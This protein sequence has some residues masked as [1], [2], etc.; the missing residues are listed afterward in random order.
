MVLQAAERMEHNSRDTLYRVPFGAVAAGKTVR[1]AILAELSEPVLEAVLR[2]WYNGRGEELVPLQEGPGHIWRAEL[3]PAEKGLVWYSF[4]F[5]TATR[6]IWYGNRENGRGGF[7]QVYAY[8]PPGY[9]LTVYARGAKSPDWLKNSIMYQIF[10]DRFCRAGNIIPQK[11]GAV[12]HTCWQDT[13]YYYREKETGDILAYDFFGGNLAG[14]RSKLSYLKELG[15]SLIYLNPIFEAESNHRYDTGDYLKIDAFLGRN[16]E[17]ALLVREA[18]EQGIRIILDG[19]FSHTG[20]NSRY[21][22]QKGEYGSI[23]AV[24]SEDSPYRR[25]YRFTDYPEK[26]ECWWRVASLPEVNELE[27]SYLD[28]IIRNEKSVLHTWLKAG[29]SGW[30]LDVIDE[31]PEEFLRLFYAELKRTAPEA[32]VIGEVWEDAS[33]KVSYGGVREYLCGGETDSVMNYPLRRLITGFLCG[34]MDGGAVMEELESLRENYPPEN[35]YAL[36]NMLGTHDVERIMTVLGDGVLPDTVPERKRAEARL[37]PAARKLAERRLRAAVLWQM[38]WPGVPSVYYG[39]EIG[40]EGQRD[41]FNRCPYDWENGSAELREFFRRAIALRRAEPALRTGELIPLFGS[42]DIYAYARIIRNGRDV[43]GKEA[44]N[45]AFVIAVNR[46]A[47]ERTVSLYAGAFAAAGEQLERLFS[48]RRE[49]LT[50]AAGDCFRV[51]LVPCETAV[52]RVLKKAPVYKREAGI[53]LHPTAL[54][55][56][57]GI[58]DIGSGARA[59]VDFL[60]RAGMRVW[61][62][63]PLQPAGKGGSP[64]QSPSA[65]AFNPLLIDLEPLYEQGLLTAGEL[66]AAALPDGEVD[67][68][69]TAAAKGRALRQAYSRA[70][71]RLEAELA[72]FAAAEAEWLDDYALFMALKKSCGGE[73]WTRWPEPLKRRDRAALVRAERSLAAEKGYFVFEQYLFVTQWRQLKQYAGS[74]GIKLFGDIPLFLAADSADVWAHQSYFALREDGEPLL[75]AG[76]PP[77]YFSRTGQLWGNPQYDWEALEKDGWSWWRARLRHLLRFHDIIRLDHFRGLEAYWEIKAEAETAAEGCWKKGPGRRLLSALE[78]ELGGLPLVA[79]DLGIIT[80]EVHEL[81]EDFH[82]PGMRV[83][84]FELLSGAAGF[85]TAEN[86]VAYTGTHDNNTLRGWYEE[87]LSPAERQRIAELTGET[88]T[89]KICRRLMQLVLESSARLAVL[90]LQDVLLLPADARFNTPGTVGGNWCFRLTELP[91]DDKAAELCSMLAAAGRYS[92][93]PGA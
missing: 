15:I 43:F 45:G 12:F 16:E 28:F 3:V 62:L 39:D 38:T 58:G 81:R 36:M 78:K 7:G 91:G 37:S 74:K 54:P 89:E 60:V 86:S 56:R 32:A 25:W 90:P 63:L 31:L 61:Q 23:G 69:A 50:I 10:P 52:F 66:A 26:Y 19:V 2:L 40:M 5:R 70:G 88:G 14:I 29:I 92:N 77:D 68:P 21:F 8:E 72:E 71:G 83:L 80:D 59:F 85:L 75:I 79:E 82:L 51:R 41:P 57:F 20:S 4:R 17:L 27:P 22:N 47:E 87:D 33:G 48:D 53:L 46:A 30:R 73:P 9:Q 49:I 34:R 11:R 55:S 64:Y 93:G 1:L 13:P 6:T 65:F 24:Q 18:A 44:E 35:F 76:V 67:F 42:G 84:E